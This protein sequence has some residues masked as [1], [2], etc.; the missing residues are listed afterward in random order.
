VLLGGMLDAQGRFEEITQT[1]KIYLFAEVL[2]KNPQWLEGKPLKNKMEQWVT[3]IIVRVIVIKWGVLNVDLTAANRIAQILR[4]LGIFLPK[5]GQQARETAE[6]PPLPSPP[7]TLP[8]FSV[9][10]LP[11]TAL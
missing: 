5:R 8:L 10:L 2:Y 1:I 4:S 11:I 3:N 6:P 7:P 9:P